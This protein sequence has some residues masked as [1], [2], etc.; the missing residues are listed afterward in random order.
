MS[1]K[2][3]NATDNRNKYLV[4]CNQKGVHF[5]INIINVVFVL[6]VDYAVHAAEMQNDRIVD[7][8]TNSK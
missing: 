3:I 2:N 1:R 8:Y 7:C 6:P 5:Y 4:L